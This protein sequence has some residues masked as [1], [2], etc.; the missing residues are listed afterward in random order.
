MLA[1]ST[2]HPL[3]VWIVTCLDASKRC[4]LHGP[5]KEN[6]ECWALLGTVGEAGGEQTCFLHARNL[7]SMAGT[8]FGDPCALRVGRA[9]GITLES[10]WRMRPNDDTHAEDVAAA[11]QR[12]VPRS[13]EEA[14]PTGTGPTRP[15][16]SP[17]DKNEMPAPG[18]PDDPDQP[19]NYPGR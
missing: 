6:G 2:G 11:G 12:P 15:E 14:V 9:H 4:W 7:G 16:T 8:Q 5:V 3:D 10:R 18:D 13:E 17:S 19:Q 1:I